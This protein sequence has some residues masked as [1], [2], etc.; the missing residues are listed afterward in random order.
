MR[1]FQ[2]WPHNSNRIK[3]DPLLARI[4]SKLAKCQS[5]GIAVNWH[6]LAFSQFWGKNK[7]SKIFPILDSLLAKSGVKCDSICILRTCMG[8][9]HNLASFRA[10]FDIIFIF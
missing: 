8:F 10:R 3:F 2:I 4:L 1:G 6:S 9:F 5:I 7:L